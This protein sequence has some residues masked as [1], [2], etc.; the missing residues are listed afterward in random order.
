MSEIL[1][2]KR[3]GELEQFDADKINKIV[4]HAVNGLSEVSS[5]DILMNAKINFYNGITTEV[6]HESLI[7]SAEDLISA[8][9]PNYSIVA[10]RLAVTALRKKVWGGNQPPRLLDHIKKC[11]EVGVYTKDL[12]NF[13]SED[14][15]NKIGEFVNHDLDETMFDYN[16]MNQM[17]K[18]VLVQDRVNKVIFETPQ[19]AYICIGMVHFSNFPKNEKLKAVKE[20]YDIVSNRELNIPTPMLTRWRTN[21]KSGASCCLISI[22]DTSDSI[23]SSA[24]IM[25]KATS[26]GYG[27]GIDFGRIRGLGS[28][29][30]GGETVH[31][32]VIPY[33]KVFQDSI[34]SQQQGGAR[35]GAGTANAPIFHWEIE[36]ILQLKN[37]G[38]TEY[39]RVRHMDYCISISKLFYD[40][41]L[42]GQDITLLSYH[43]CPE[44]YDSFGMPEFDDLYIAAENNPKIKF[45][46][47]ISSDDLFN[48]LVKERIETNRI[49][50]LNIDLANEY[51]PWT[52]RVRMT[53]LC[54]VSKDTLVITL[55]GRE[56]GYSNVENLVGIPTKIYNGKGFSE[57]V[58]EKTSDESEMIRVGVENKDGKMVNYLNCTNYHK[59]YSDE[60]EKIDAK[61][62]VVGQ[63]LCGFKTIWGERE[64]DQI[65]VSIEKAESGPTYC[66]PEPIA[67]KIVFN[68]ILTGNCEILQP[69]TP[70]QMLNDPNGEI[71]TCLLAAV[72]MLNIKNDEHHRKVCH[73]AV[74]MLNEMIDRQEYFDLAAENF[75]KNRRSL[76][77]G[78]TNLAGWLAHREMNHDSPE[79]PNAIDEF[80][81]KQQYFLME[82]SVELAKKKGPAPFWNRSKYSKGYSK[83]DLYKKNIDS[84]IT[85]KP[86]MDWDKLNE[87]IK[88]YGMYNMTLSSQMPCEKSSQIQNSTNGCEPIIALFQFKDDREGAT[89]WIAPGIKKYGKYYK[90]A[91]D[92]SNEGIIKTM[93]AII[94]WT[95]MGASVTHYY[96]YGNYDNG[97]LDM[98][99]AMNDILMSYECGLPTLYYAKTKQV[100][101]K[102]STLVE[103]EEVAEEI[104]EACS[105]NGGCSL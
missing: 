34:K 62:L 67:G 12:L 98:L 4:F 48:S 46:K 83:L 66:A 63:K 50:I 99:D 51:R 37:V 35:R 85:R 101:N 70:S 72:N 21:T 26:L 49:Y 39:N 93:S 104:E 58:F 87:D 88:K 22:D 103:V 20:F 36:S 81:E 24:H 60:N 59:F 68:G 38:G 97:K 28:P 43:E 40:R 61:D 52:E 100:V 105:I 2:K 33:L 79:A 9:N 76:G 80:M 19:F 69:T 18:M 29:V 13:Y 73:L 7:K 64:V 54:C 96:N 41:Y 42:N 23:F 90:S 17:L 77:I 57:V 82:A 78:I 44:V 86:S 3:N 1:V 55:N 91:Y 53:N 92:C 95:D 84:F 56:V 6:I 10:S 94:K 11:V 65:V 102:D 71:G 31:S 32:G 74:K 89:A 15:I 14:E 47:S 16:G 8:N 30:K 27:L 75:T 5:N 45:K 25:A